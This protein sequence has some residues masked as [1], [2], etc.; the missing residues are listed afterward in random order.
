MKI[1]DHIDKLQTKNRDRLLID[2]F[3]DDEKVI[4]N[5]VALQR[6]LRAYDAL[7]LLCKQYE[8][9]IL[10]QSERIS[11]LTTCEHT[12]TYIRN[13]KIQVANLQKEINDIKIAAGNF[14]DLTV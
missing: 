5:A 1:V 13:L 10:R 14:Y 3:R 7:K 9:Q 2:Y 8:T 4:V 6:E 12:E 11:R